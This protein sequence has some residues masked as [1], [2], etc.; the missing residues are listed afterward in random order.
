MILKRPG[1]G[2]L[3]PKLEVPGL[4]RPGWESNPGQRVSTVG[5]EHPIENSLLIAIRNIYKN[6][7]IYEPAKIP[8]NN[9]YLVRLSL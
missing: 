6:I 5:G 1:Q 4:T 2:H 3:H 7:Y 9:I 8:S